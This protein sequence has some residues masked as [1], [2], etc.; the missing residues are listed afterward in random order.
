MSNVYLAIYQ[1]FRQAD[2]VLSPK[3]RWRQKYRA[4]RMRRKGYSEQKINPVQM[5][6]STWEGIRF[7]EDAH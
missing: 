2:W 1:N 5:S 7:V 3:E 6:V 4:E